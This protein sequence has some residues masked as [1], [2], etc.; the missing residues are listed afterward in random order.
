MPKGGKKT[1]EDDI[2]A[3]HLG[4]IAMQRR[5]VQGVRTTRKEKELPFA[6]K[7]ADSCKYWADWVPVPIEAAQGQL[8]AVRH[9]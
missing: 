6:N 1:P 8:I 3:Q 2:R 9:A 7:F 5:L 4:V